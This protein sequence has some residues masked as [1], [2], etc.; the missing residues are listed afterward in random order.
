MKRNSFSNEYKTY[1]KTDGWKTKAE[2]RKKVD[3]Y[4]CAICGK[5][6]NL[7][8]HHLHY[9]TFMN[10]NPETD[11]VTLC[12]ECHEHVHDIKDE[13]TL[14]IEAGT[15]FANI[16]M[17]DGG[18][19]KFLKSLGIHKDDSIQ[20]ATEYAIE[21]SAILYIKVQEGGAVTV[22]YSRGFVKKDVQKMENYLGIKASEV[23]RTAKQL[24]QAAIEDGWW[25]GPVPERW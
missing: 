3:G 13:I 23:E 8:V 1:I 22:P 4:K 18:Y 5:T 19:E 16:I 24:Y 14:G 10:E 20:M 6:D 12:K 17:M 11:L 25:I 15:M 7:Q 9:K 2:I 21:H